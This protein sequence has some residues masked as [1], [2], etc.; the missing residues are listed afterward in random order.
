MEKSSNFPPLGWDATKHEESQK[1]SVHTRNLFQSPCLRIIRFSF[2]SPLCG[3]VRVWLVVLVKVKR[4]H[5]CCRMPPSSMGP[6][7][8]GKLALD[9]A[10]LWSSMLTS[11]YIQFIQVTHFGF[12]LHVSTY[13][14]IHQCYVSHYMNFSENFCVISRL[15]DH[16]LN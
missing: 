8:Q 3:F 2:L 15:I 10:S 13:R 7:R 5:I 9:F 12:A 11:F 4:N 6:K 1:C 14:N 16:L